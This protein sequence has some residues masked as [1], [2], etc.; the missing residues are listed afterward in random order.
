MKWNENAHK[1]FQFCKSYPEYYIRFYF[2]NEITHAHM[3]AKHQRPQNI[4]LHIRTNYERIL[5]ILLTNNL[6]DYHVATINKDLML[7]PQPSCYSGMSILFMYVCGRGRVGVW[8]FCSCIVGD[9]FDPSYGS[10][11]FMS[12]KIG[13]N[14]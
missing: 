5:Q 2:V 7:E 3:D 1:N 12:L 4:L 14:L 8:T 6:Y 9:I 13:N 10:N 11:L